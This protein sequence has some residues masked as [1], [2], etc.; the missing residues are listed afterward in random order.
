LIFLDSF[1]LEFELPSDFGLPP[2]PNF[3]ARPPFSAPAYGFTQ[4]EPAPDVFI[5]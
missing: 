3:A 2:L 5:P 4:S 1:E